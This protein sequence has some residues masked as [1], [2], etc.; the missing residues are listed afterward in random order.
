MNRDTIL[1]AMLPE[2]LLLAGIVSLVVI[3]MVRPRT[4]AAAVL[5]LACVGG[6]AVAAA[7]LGFTGYSG[8]PFEGQFSVDPWT[9]LAKAVALALALPVLLLVRDEFGDGGPAPA[10]LLSSLYGLTLMLS[11]DSF[12]TLFLGV[13]MMSLP[14][15]V[16]VLLAMRRVES[17]EA[18]LKYLVLGGAASATLLMGVSL[19]YG[20]YDT[21]LLAVFKRALATADPMALTGAVMVLAAFFL[22]AAIVPFHAW[23]PDAYE[24]ASLPVTAYMA[25]V[26]KAGVLLAVLRLF[27]AAD[28]P[29]TM[30]G[31]LAVLPLASIVWGNLAAMRQDNLRRMMAYSSIAHAGYLYVA[32]LGVGHGR[33]ES[34]LY[35]II[36]YGLMTVL[37][38]AAV[39]P[40]ADDPQRDRLAQLAGLFQRQPFAA[41]AIGLAML[42]L[43]GV[44]PLP[45]F[46]AKFLIFR[47]VMAEGHTLVA[48]LGLIGSYL[49]LYFYL[50][51]IQAMFMT[52][53][54]AAPAHTPAPHGA[55]LAAMLLCLA[56]ALVLMLFPGW[57]LSLF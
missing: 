30:V 16:L 28:L 2:H 3:E 17:A 54:A 11:A 13:E 36:A 26:I 56:P 22:K 35:Y 31:L 47:E 38:F 39:P 19:L 41:I 25:V 53:Q 1:V 4:R 21:L 45:G 33:F 44:P 50:R 9:L 37:A 12:L 7:W 57:V 29:A 34:V 10:L 55:A 15:Y 49:G 48:V 24:G 20:Q 42:S 23:A 5:A 18:A 51:V 40:H 43:A 46:V 8:T 32:L 6:A 27:G 52:P 14:V